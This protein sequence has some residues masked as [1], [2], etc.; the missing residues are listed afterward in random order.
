MSFFDNIRCNDAQL[1][2]L[3]SAL[4]QLSDIIPLGNSEYNFEYHAPDPDKVEL[5][6]STEVALNNVLEV[7]FAPGGRKDESPTCPRTRASLV[8]VVDVT[9]GLQLP[10]TSFLIPRCFK[11]GS[12]IMTICK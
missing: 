6:G 3:R 12:V 8:A 4:E 9:T 7:T 5:Y 11:N 10:S 2:H 1:S